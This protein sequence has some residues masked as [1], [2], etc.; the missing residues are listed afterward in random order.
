MDPSDLVYRNHQWTTVLCD[1]NESCATPGHVVKFNGKNMMM[2]TF[3]TIVSCGKK[4]MHVNSPRY[5]RAVFINSKTEGLQY[6]V[7]AARYESRL[8]EAVISAAVRMGM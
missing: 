6:T 1:A 4:E 3:C 8:E 5:S 7:F 2:K